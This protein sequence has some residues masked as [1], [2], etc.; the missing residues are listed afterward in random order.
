[1]R[2]MPAKGDNRCLS[3]ISDEFWRNGIRVGESVSRGKLAAGKVIDIWM[4]S[5]NNVQYEDVGRF[6]RIIKVIADNGEHT[7]DSRIDI[8]ELVLTLV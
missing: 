2:T 5:Q 1:M 3:V 6:K 4:Q 8:G 7:S